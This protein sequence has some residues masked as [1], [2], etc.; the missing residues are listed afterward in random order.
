M[1]YSDDSILFCDIFEE[2][3]STVLRAMSL[4]RDLGFQVHLEKSCLIPKQEIE[5]LE[6][7]INSKNTTVQLI[8]ETNLIL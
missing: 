2:C 4:F 8:K 3:K 1:S 7:L 5:L 6:F